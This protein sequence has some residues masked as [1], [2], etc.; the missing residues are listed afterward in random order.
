MKPTRKKRIKQ[1]T[2]CME[3]HLWELERKKVFDPSFYFDNMKKNPTV[4]LDLE[5]KIEKLN[6]HLIRKGIKRLK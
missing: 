6:A 5:I 2:S 3:M 4:K 1:A